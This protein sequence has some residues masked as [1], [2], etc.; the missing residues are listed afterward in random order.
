MR[1]PLPPRPAERS[2]G[3]RLAV[4]AFVAMA[5]F[6]PFAVLAILVISA[7]W[8]LRTLDH[9]LAD[10]L[11]AYALSHPDLVDA[12]QVWST[13]FGPGPLRVLVLVVAVLL[14]W[15]GAR[16]TAI[17]AVITMAAGGV[18]GAVLKLIFGRGRPDLLDPVAHAP[19]YS[20]PSGH[21]LNAAL[22]ASVL[23]LALLPVADRVRDDA[24]RRLLRWSM[25]AVAA[26]VTAITGLC[27][28]ALGVHWTSDVLGGW[29][30]G[31][32]LA[33][34][35]TAAFATWLRRPAAEPVGEQEYGEQE[36]GDQESG[37]Q[38]SGEQEY[39]DVRPPHA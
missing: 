34:A 22:A 2:L 38:K 12:A 39:A 29:V 35:T 5:V 31:A 18:L 9:R 16:R 27:R 6:V 24:R 1:A 37:E 19:G 4:T 21:A 8:P 7:W 15:R 20:F 11:H 3:V 10:A 33:A 25:W 13:V 26:V 23:V 36:Y 17:W 28:I 32:A 30:L 14:W